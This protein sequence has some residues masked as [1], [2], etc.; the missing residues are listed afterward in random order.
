MLARTL[1]WLPAALALARVLLNAGHPSPKRPLPV[2]SIP[3][4]MPL[5][6]LA[7]VAALVAAED[8][9]M[10]LCGSHERPQGTATL[11]GYILLCA[12]AAAQLNT[13]ARAQK[14]I[15]AMNVGLADAERALARV[16]ETRADYREAERLMREEYEKE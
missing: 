6:L 14:V 12:L 16:D 3:L 8:W 7:L 5:T 1:I 10:A 15:T 11:L 4:T 13:V 2:P 9:R